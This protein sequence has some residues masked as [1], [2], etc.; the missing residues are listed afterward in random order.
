MLIEERRQEATR[1][2]RYFSL[3]LISQPLVA[4]FPS[5]TKTAV[6]RAYAIKTSVKSFIKDNP[7]YSHGTYSSTNGKVP[8][9]STPTISQSW[10]S[11]LLASSPG[12]K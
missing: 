1:S 7:K 4:Q 9:H 12:N 10:F 3:R 8:C 2:D 6:D 5:T 11:H